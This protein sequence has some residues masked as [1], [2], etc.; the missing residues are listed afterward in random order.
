M[1]PPEYPLDLTSSAIAGVGITPASSIT[2]GVRWIPSFRRLSIHGLETRVSYPTSN[3]P[4]SLS[5][6]ACPIARTAV[7]LSGKSP[8]RERI[9]SVPKSFEF[10]VFFEFSLQHGLAWFP[11]I[12]RGNPAD[13]DRPFE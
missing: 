4:P 6:I 13:P 12:G 5:P 3:L 9:P 7:A 8:A 10:M 1:M 11:E 2:A